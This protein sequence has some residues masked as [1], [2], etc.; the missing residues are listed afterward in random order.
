[1]IG[2]GTDV[3]SP[4]ML[5]LLTGLTAPIAFAFS[6]RMLPASPIRSSGANI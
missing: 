5:A 1:V 4:W 3:R 6:Y 2:A